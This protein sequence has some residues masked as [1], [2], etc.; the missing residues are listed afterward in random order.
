MAAHRSE[1]IGNDDQHALTAAYA[2]ESPTPS[3]VPASRARPRRLSPV[4]DGPAADTF[5]DIPTNPATSC[6]MM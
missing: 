6:S 2:D 5:E 4:V 1:N 3:A